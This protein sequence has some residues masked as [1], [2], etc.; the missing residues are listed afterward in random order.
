M[1]D[2]Y[3]IMLMLSFAYVLA[4]FPT[5]EACS[6]R[7]EY[8]IISG[9]SP[10]GVLTAVRS[11]S[12][13]FTCYRLTTKVRYKFIFDYK[14]DFLLKADYKDKALSYAFTEDVVGNKTKHRSET[15]WTGRGYSF[16]QL[17]EE[18]QPLDLNRIGYSV[19]KLYF[20]A[21]PAN[22]LYVYSEKHGKNFPL[23]RL[24]PHKYQMSPKK[25]QTNV[26][27]FDAHGRCKKVSVNRGV[28]S[29]VMRLKSSVSKK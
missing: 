17:G 24:G 27:D 29:F 7:L 19:A 8:E 21:P 25:G 16:R 14:I 1:T 20:E 26:Y 23:K 12:A 6:Q 18:A 10:I 15:H 11:D 13:G 22:A 4:F 9:N 5:G 2:G 3:R 28:T